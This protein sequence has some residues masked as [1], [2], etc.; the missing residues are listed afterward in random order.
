M[1]RMRDTEHTRTFM[2]LVVLRL[3]EPAVTDGTLSQDHGETLAGRARER[4]EEDRSKGIVPHRRRGAGRPGERKEERGGEE[5]RSRDGYGGPAGDQE[6]GEGENQG[7]SRADGQKK[8]ER[9]TTSVCQGVLQDPPTSG[10]S[11]PV[12]KGRRG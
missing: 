3:L 7:R 6:G 1:E 4:K 8:Q 5:R 11:R 9:A 2:A 10:I 12:G